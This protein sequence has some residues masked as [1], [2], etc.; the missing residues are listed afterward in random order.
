MASA[1][2]FVSSKTNEQVVKIRELAV[3]HITIQRSKLLANRSMPSKDIT[4]DMIEKIAKNI[5]LYE[6]HLLA[7][8]DYNFLPPL[9]YPDILKIIPRNSVVV[10]VANNFANDSFR[11]RVSLK[12][13]PEEIAEACAFLSTEFLEIEMSLNPKMEVVEEILTLYKYFYTFTN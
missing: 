4:E 7:I 9:P 12:Y 5:K 3:N 13:S 6:F 8:L 11:T 1:T 2:I 10:R